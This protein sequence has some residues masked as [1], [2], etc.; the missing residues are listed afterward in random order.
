MWTDSVPSICW[1]TPAEVPEL[2]KNPPTFSIRCESGVYESAYS[3]GFIPTKA[4]E[5]VFIMFCLVISF[6]ALP[7]D[8]I[9]TWSL[10]LA[11]IQRGLDQL[12]SSWSSLYILSLIN[13]NIYNLPHS[14][15]WPIWWRCRNGDP[16]VLKSL[17]RYMPSSFLS[18]ISWH[19][20]L[21]T[22]VK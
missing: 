6:E 9:P 15:S 17:K 7:V 1:F 14:P 13:K 16:K 3:G 12:L 21:P 18:W 20:S 8:E 2:H 11:L 22:S 4:R 5:K 19:S 10:F